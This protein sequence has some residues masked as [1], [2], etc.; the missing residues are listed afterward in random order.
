MLVRAEAERPRT[1]LMVFFSILMRG[2]GHDVR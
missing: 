1:L 2:V